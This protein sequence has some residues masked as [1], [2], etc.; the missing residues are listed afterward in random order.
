MSVDLPTPPL[1]EATQITLPHLG[2]RPLGQTGAA[3]AFLQLALLGVG[4]HVESDRHFAN[5]VQRLDRAGHRGLE[6][7]ADRA[8]GGGQRDRHVD[9][10]AVAELDRAHH[11]QLDDRPPQLG[12]D[13]RLQRLEDLFARGH[14]V[15]CRKPGTGRQG[16][17]TAIQA[18]GRC[19]CTSWIAETGAG[20][21]AVTRAGHPARPLKDRRDATKGV[22]T[23][24][25]GEVLQVPARY[26][27][28]TLSLDPASP[29]GRQ[30]EAVVRKR[31]WPRA[32]GRWRRPS[33]DADRL[34]TR[35]CAK[36]AC[37]EACGPDAG[38]RG[39]PDG[40]RAR[41]ACGCA[42]STRCTALRR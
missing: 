9:P 15:H 25:G 7:A 39:A 32:P 10:P 13:H 21:P 20:A 3:Q 2:H 38:R 41:R 12:I 4:E 33:A 17:V 40:P 11:P 42:C 5:S 18:L 8:A 28:G 16:S 19:T 37:W 6:V 29:R 30:G 24:E 34:V 35:A 26:E 23:V 22:P 14:R 36:P 27:A 1:P 31:C